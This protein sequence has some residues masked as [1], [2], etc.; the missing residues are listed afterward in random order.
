MELNLLVLLAD[1]CESILIIFAAI[2]KECRLHLYAGLCCE[3]LL[4]LFVIGMAV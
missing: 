2:L 3:E 1:Y 4:V